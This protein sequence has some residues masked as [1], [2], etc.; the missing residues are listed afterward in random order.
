MF[1]EQ[2]LRDR[3]GSNQE[4]TNVFSQQLWVQSSE[5]IVNE[6][7]SCKILSGIEQWDLTTGFELVCSHQ[8]R[9]PF[10]QFQ[11]GQQTISNGF[12][13]RVQCLLNRL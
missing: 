5:N 7:V 8:A 13:T 2:A 10:T 4:E 1:T 3:S 11:R 9:I 12:V 6:A